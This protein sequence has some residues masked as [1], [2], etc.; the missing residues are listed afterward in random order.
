MFKGHRQQ[1]LIQVF[2]VDAGIFLLLKLERTGWV[3]LGTKQVYI[4]AKVMANVFLRESSMKL[5]LKDC[6]DKKFIH[7]ILMCIHIVSLQWHPLIEIL[8]FGYGLDLLAEF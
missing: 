5:S 2:A 4:E 1:I 6:I 7:Q 8:V 3:W